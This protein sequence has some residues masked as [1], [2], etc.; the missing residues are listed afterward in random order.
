MLTSSDFNFLKDMDFAA[1]NGTHV[2]KSD[3]ERLKKIAFEVDV[4]ADAVVRF[5]EEL[6]EDEKTIGEKALQYIADMPLYASTCGITYKEGIRVAE[7]LNPHWQEEMVEMERFNKLSPEDQ[8][9]E[10]KAI[11]GAKA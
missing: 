7:A 1:K 11:T 4:I 10:I 5:N 2:S 8:L 6:K 9:K 3:K